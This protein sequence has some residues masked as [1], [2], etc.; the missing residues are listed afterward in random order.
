MSIT[1]TPGLLEREDE[2][3][4]LRHAITGASDGAGGLVVLRG[5]AGVGKTRLLARARSDAAAAGLNVLEAR[6]APLE[7]AFAFGVARQLFEAPVLAE[8]DGLLSGAARLSERLFGEAGAPLEA[9]GSDAAFG[10]LHGLYW[11]T[12]NLAD[13]GPLM[14]AVDDAQWADAPS[15]RFL[16]YLAGRLDGLPVV[17]VAAGRMP[18]P[19]A[20]GPLWQE[21]AD[22]GTPL[23]LRPLSESASADVVRSSLPGADDEFCRA[24]HDA[25]GGNP[26]FLRELVTAAEDAELAPTAASAASVTTVGAPAVSRFVLRRLERLGPQATA[27]AQA[28]AVLGDAADARLAGQ[29]AGLDET[30]AGMVIDRLVTADVL[31]PSQPPSFAHPIVRAAVYEDLLPGERATRHA[32]AAALLAD[33]GAPVERVAAHLLEAAPA[34]DAERVAVLRSAA[35]RA[36]DRG[37]PSAAAS[38]LERALAEPPPPAA[39]SEIVCELGR[40]EVAR[41]DFD[42]AEQHLLDA[43]AA[44]ADPAVHARA[45]TW[46]A[47]C[48]LASGSTT[49]PAAA[50]DRLLS[51]LEPVDHDRSLEVEAELISLCMNHL[52]LRAELPAR[53][54]RLRGRAAGDARFE[55]VTR[56]FDAVERS[57]DLAPADAVADEIEAALAAGP[58]AALPAN[59][60][61]IMTLRVNGRYEGAARWLELALAAA[62]AQGLSGQLAIIHGER[63]CLALARGAVAGAALEADIGLELIGERHFML[64]RLAAAA[65]DAATERGDLAA[66]AAAIDRGVAEGEHER[67]FL[68]E[69]LTARGKLLAV[70]GEP[71]QALTDLLRVGEVLQ[72]YGVQRPDDWRPHAALA[73]A[74]AGEPEQAEVLAREHLEAARVFGAPRALGLALRAAGRTTGDV[75]LLEE[76]VATLE[77]SPA[78]LELAHA[79]ADLGAELVRR[80]RR[81]EGRE[82]L[83]AAAEQALACGATALAQR[84]RGELGAGGGR[85]A[86]MELTGVNA[87]TPAERR[88]CELAAGESTNREIAQTLF[89]TEKTVELHLTNAYRKLGIRS[90]FQLAGALTG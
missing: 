4:R 65:A 78:R 48:A 45:A 58:L 23:A 27:F 16:S 63:A 12:A 59:F 41:Q 35:R 88:V 51:E 89:V 17:L 74:A 11:L 75:A 64:P 19:E 18:D 56:V 79:R 54:E 84:A 90:R 80:R 53:L 82:Q 81:T 15:L 66:A 26:L 32:A 2:L 29:A 34:G 70:R 86:R 67:L 60:L 10:A 30:E 25:T 36:A 33:A 49:V 83:R 20:A 9:Q 1:S 8:P 71:R 24:C 69:L 14:L 43:L 37:A 5:P 46:L 42:A 38:F 7:R 28:L 21:L 39:R 62:R 68:D 31:A 55:R 22:G 57:L 13:R 50:L 76:A 85:R 72:A 3:R 52:P 44:P 40:W 61:A 73:L 87:L 77:P 6:G 47:R